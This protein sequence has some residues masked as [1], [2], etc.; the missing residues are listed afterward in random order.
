METRDRGTGLEAELLAAIDRGDYAPGDRLPSVG[1]LAKTWGAN[2]NTVSRAIQRLKGMG[3]LTGP[4][5]GTTR[6]RP[7]PT[8]LVRQ[9]PD[10]Y[11]LEK[12]RA[13][14]PETERERTGATEM[15]TGL[16]KQDL[17]FEPPTLSVVQATADQAALFGVD[18]G[19]D[20]LARRYRTRVG[21]TEQLLSNTTSYLLHSV[22]SR[23]VDLLTPESKPWAG[24]TMNQLRSVGIEVTHI[25]DRVTTRPPRPEEAEELGLD[26]G[27]AV[28][29][30]R[31]L[32]YA[33]EQLVEYSDF[34]LPGDVT[35]LVYRTDL[36][37]WSN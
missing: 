31:K 9:Q 4:A 36:P 19:T 6:V 24:G 21:E 30:F 34:V 22:A 7:A 18:E 14:L 15:D 20:L 23:N 5:G 16:T 25:I 29:V 26:Q 37:E 33:G 35:E 2:K 13:R 3:V 8:R 28:F 10:R 1:E 17:A 11:M 32:C 27:V 12:E